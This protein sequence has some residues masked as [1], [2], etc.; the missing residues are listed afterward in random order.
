MVQTWWTTRD[1]PG[2]S[3]ASTARNA[4]SPWPTSALSSTEIISTA[5][6]AP[7]NCELHVLLCRI[8]IHQLWPSQGSKEVIS[9]I[10]VLHE[11]VS[12]HSCNFGSWLQYWKCNL[13][14]K[15]DKFAKA[16]YFV[17]LEVVSLAWTIY[18]HICKRKH[19]WYELASKKSCLDFDMQCSDGIHAQ[20]PIRSLQPFNIKAS[21]V[22]FCKLEGI[23][24][25]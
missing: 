9:I 22:P 16:S 11:L 2:M 4:A 24:S 13:A 12:H 6:T 15:I 5:P 19:V 21:S 25:I 10:S 1:T 20:N 18:L 3:T 7:R 14:S 8:T 23:M 17:G